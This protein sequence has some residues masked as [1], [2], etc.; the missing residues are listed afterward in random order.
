MLASRLQGWNW[1]ASCTH[2]IYFRDRQKNLMQYFEMVESLSYC[3]NIDGLTQALGNEHKSE[4]WR[5]FID[6]SIFNLKV[7]LLHIG[8][9]HPFIYS[10]CIPIAHALNMRVL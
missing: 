9:I 6:A 10:H 4:K 7:T 8:Y 5:L 1:L 3:S 2:N